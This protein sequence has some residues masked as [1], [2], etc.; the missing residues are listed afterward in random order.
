[1][2]RTVVI[3]SS[4]AGA[5][6]ATECSAGYKV[7][8]TLKGLT[9]DSAKVDGTSCNTNCCEKD[10]KTCGGLSATCNAGFYTVASDATQ[11][12]KDTWANTAA[13][14]AT[15]KNVCCTPQVKCS[16]RAYT[17]PAGYT[18]DSTNAGDSCPDNA[19]SCIKVPTTCCKPDTTKCGGNA[20]A[21]SQACTDAAAPWFML[22]DKT[23]DSWKDTTIVATNPASPQ[24]DEVKNSCCGVKLTCSMYKCPAGKKQQAN[25]NGATLCTGL[26]TSTCETSCCQA[27]AAK[28]TCGTEKSPP[29]CPVDQFRDSSLNDKLVG[30]SSVANCC[31]AKATCATKRCP[32]GGKPK[33]SALKNF[34]AGGAS[35]CKTAD[36]C[37]FDTK[38]CGGQT[39]IVC[40]KGFYL[41]STMF[42]AEKYTQAQQDAWNAKPTTDKTKNKDC[43][44]AQAVCSAEV[45]GVT[46][47]PAAAAAT[48]TPAAARLFSEHKA[49]TRKG[50][51]ED[52]GVFVAIGA[53]A[54]MSVLF[55][56]SKMRQSSRYTQIQA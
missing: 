38:T 27:D 35:T 45:A 25:T 11:A 48:T 47:T 15:S 56:A 18:Y 41:E 37:E 10:D 32:A 42:V 43:C 39:G 33:K 1:M 21:G 14:A 24:A 16:S 9:C 29:A 6:A 19:A 51:H 55:V 8:K 44:T 12:Q 34:C 53:M 17:C 30:K 4:I 54:G 26:T 52:N 2:M 28:T 23:S 3:A 7:K 20:A 5:V 13:T 40:A 50:K 22:P 36:C 46:T 49:A 31:S